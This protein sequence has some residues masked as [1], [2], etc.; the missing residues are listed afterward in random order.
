[1]RLRITLDLNMET[2]PAD[3]KARNEAIRQLEQALIVSVPSTLPLDTPL[4]ER[5]ISFAL[6]NPHWS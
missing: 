5:E 4:L 1:M 6:L 2:L 3:E